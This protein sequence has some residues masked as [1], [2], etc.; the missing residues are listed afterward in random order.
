VTPEQLNKI[1]DVYAGSPPCNFPTMLIAEID[2]LNEAI[3]E[4]KAEAWKEGARAEREQ[5]NH[6][7]HPINPYR[8]ES[9]DA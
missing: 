8:K 5:W 1:R 3:N 6:V 2:R 9:P 7:G 4:A